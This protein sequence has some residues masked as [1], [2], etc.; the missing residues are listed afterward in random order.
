AVPL[1]TVRIHGVDYAWIYQAPPEVAQARQADFGP[2]VRLRGYNLQAPMH[3]G[4]TQSIELNWQV[5]GRAP[6]D[7][8]LFAHLIGPDGKR[9]GQLDLPYPISSWNPG[10]YLST[11][12]P[13]AVAA[14][15]Q[16]GTYRLVVG[17]YD[18]VTQQRLPLTSA[19]RLDPA[20]DGPD[21]LLLAEVRVE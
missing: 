1:H 9:Y 21:A 2:N 19:D 16:P 15:A 10:S 18:P 13:L 5:L 3:A 8:M 12:L 20:I 14:D 4:Q 7:A 17:M 11:E 6:A